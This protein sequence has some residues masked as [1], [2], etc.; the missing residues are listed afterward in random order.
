M[1][2]ALA[3]LAAAII[4]GL[5]LAFPIEEGSPL[6]A[7]RRRARELFLSKLNDAQRRS[8]AFERRFDLIAPSGRRYTIAPYASFNIYTSETSYCLRVEGRI[9]AYDKLL[10][11]RLLVEADEEMFLSLANKRERPRDL[12][13][14]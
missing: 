12:D 5:V 8:W 14:D 6:V 2:S 10:A 1:V 4:I 7:A 9:P 11:Q 3:L 13:F